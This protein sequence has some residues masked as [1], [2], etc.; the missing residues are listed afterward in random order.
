[1]KLS[2]ELTKIS[3]KLNQ[4]FQ[5]NL[6]QHTEKLAISAQKEINPM[7]QEMLYLKDKVKNRFQEK[8]KLKS[9]TEGITKGITQK[10]M[11]P[12]NNHTPTV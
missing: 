12:G 1:M 9:H 5:T 11:K 7:Q 3:E 6:K 10:E 2:E 8:M 4:Q